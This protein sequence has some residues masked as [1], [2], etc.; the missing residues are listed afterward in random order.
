MP[1]RLMSVLDMR[2][3]E[4]AVVSLLIAHSFFLGIGIVLFETAASGIFLHRFPAESLPLAFLGAAVC[5]PATGLLYS[6]AQRLVS[7]PVLWVG[8]LVFLLLV[9]LAL[10]GLLHLTSAAWPALLMMALTF[11][12]SAIAA[13]EFWGLAGRILDLRQA[14]RLYGLIGAGEISAGIVGGFAVSLLL[15]AVSLTTLLLIAAGGIALCLVFLIRILRSRDTSGTEE[16]DEEPLPGG[17]LGLVRSIASDRY[18]LIIGGLYLVYSL[19]HDTVD[20]LNLVQIQGRLGGSSEELAAFIGVLYSVRQ[21]VVLVARTLLAG[22]LLA[23]FGLGTA[24]SATPTLVVVAAVGMVVAA[25]LGPSAGLLFWPVIGLKITERTFWNTMGKPA[26]LVAYRPLTQKRRDR[27]QLF[28]ETIVEP[29]ST[30]LAGAILLLLA[31]LLGGLSPGARSAG[32][33]VFLTLTASAWLFMAR[34]L[35]TAYTGVVVT[36]L[37][38]GTLHSVV[39]RLDAAT[40]ADLG[41]WLRNSKAADTIYILG[42]MEESLDRARFTLA[43]EGL[44]DHPDPEVRADVLARV[45]RLAIERLAGPI[46]AALDRETSPRV[47]AA[48]LRA[49]AALGE[50]GM[51]ERITP[52]L[53]D[54]DPLLRRSALVAL[55]KYNGVAGV[56]AAGNRLLQLMGSKEATDRRIAAEVVGEVGVHAFYHPLRALLADAD[57]EVRGAAIRAAGA[58]AHPR[59]WPDLVADLARPILWKQASDALARGGDGA[60]AALADALDGDGATRAVRT[61][62]VRTIGRVRGAEAVAVLR[63]HLFTPLGWMRS[64]VLAA[65]RELG[66]RA[67]DDEQASVEE[68]LRREVALAAVANA[69]LIDL[70]DGE[71]G[72]GVT[73][74]RRSCEHEL[75]R[76]C[77]RALSCLSFINDVDSMRQVRVQL[78]SGSPER[79]TFALEVFDNLVERRHRALLL[80][81]LEG[82][83]REPLH[84]KLAAHFPEPLVG[85]DARLRLIAEGLPWVTPWMSR[86]AAHALGTK[87]SEMEQTIQKIM[88]L[89]S[90]EFFSSTDDD[91]LA[92]LASTLTEVR[93]KAGDHVIERG[94]TDA[95]MYIVESGEVR[96]H[97]DDKTL[98]VLGERAVLGEF[99]ALDPQPR[100]ASV[101]ATKD[102][103]LLRI[104]HATLV[105]LMAEHIEVAHGIIRY[106]IRRYGRT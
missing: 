38:R 46:S 95:C 5:V 75:A 58:L 47:R 40:I 53:D 55:L 92:E 56:L 57:P 26:I 67:G 14:K 8:S 76:A 71:D 102:S 62:V 63:R 3:G 83:A 42:V 30:G 100:S 96:A 88:L 72:P 10:V 9:Q 65:L 7:P 15:R 70:G 86:F 85:R 101:T 48:L 50:A 49:L 6:R 61:R 64:E 35:R 73:L 34:R 4:G 54:A 28:I 52:F 25:L 33:A 31:N 39:V 32:V 66:W 82:H 91:V 20:Y 11:V 18:I 93:Y 29:V 41:R 80:P 1:R 97:I 19:S 22:R 36:A 105:D 98:S 21:I 78:R 45:E 84:R 37:R 27:A 51:L 16:D 94:K 99:G 44:L 69:T 12:M 90:V 2:P 87:E 74:L 43:L 60:V 104:D 106:L 17:L 23:R 24:L 89:K 68:I 13:L 81:L 77:E 79:R 103:V 59:L